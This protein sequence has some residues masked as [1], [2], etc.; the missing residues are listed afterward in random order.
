MAEKAEQSYVLDSLIGVSLS[1]LQVPLNGRRNVRKLFM[2]IL[3]WL[4]GLFV[5]VVVV[6]VLYGPLCLS[7][8]IPYNVTL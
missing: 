3:L 4:L 6:A 1:T 7:V 8:R 2:Q 5:V